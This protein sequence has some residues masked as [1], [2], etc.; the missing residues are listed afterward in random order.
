[1]D[2]IPQHVVCKQHSDFDHYIDDD[3]V[4]AV[5]SVIN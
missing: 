1:V 3:N 4:P 2:E 5:V